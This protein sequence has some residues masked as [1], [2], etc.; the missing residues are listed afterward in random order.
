MFN[1]KRFTAALGVLL[2]LVTA[3]TVLLSQTGGVRRGEYGPMLEGF[4]QHV[5]F[6]G[7]MGNNTTVYTSPISGFPAG[8]LYTDGLTATDLSYA[9]AGTGCDAEDSTTE[10]TAD[11]ILYANNA[12][13][14]LGMFCAV[15][16]SGSNGVTLNV[17]A[18]AANV[19]PNV[20]VTIPTTE[21][22]G[23]ADAFTTANVAAN[24]TFAV[25]AVTTEDL[26]TAAYWCDVLIQVIP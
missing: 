18:A 21:T 6:C 20:T 5:I 10:A 2:V 14:V 26:S 1:F 4:T 3:S 19:T 8:I 11:E 16:S 9:L 13:R 15:T 17:R 24:S 25:R 22:T 12:V 23:V 7:D